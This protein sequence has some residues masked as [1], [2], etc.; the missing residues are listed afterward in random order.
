MYDASDDDE[1]V[2]S[3]DDEWT[4]P[5][6]KLS[7]R[8]QMEADAKNFEDEMNGELQDTMNQLHASN[9]LVPIGASAPEKP[10]EPSKF[11]DDIY[12]DSDIEDEATPTTSKGKRRKKNLVISD[13][14]LLYDPTMDQADQD[15]VDQ[16]RRDYHE[17][18]PR[19]QMTSER[20]SNKPKPLPNSD[21]V[22]NCPACMTLL[23]LDCQRHDK[24]HGQYRAMFVLNCRVDKSQVLNYPMTANKKSIK[25]NKKSKTKTEEDT[26]VP[27]EEVETVE[28]GCSSSEKYNPVQCE[29]CTTEVAVFDN[30]E[31][32]HFFN[33]I[34]GF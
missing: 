26:M 27:N 3:S 11:Y 33:V 12:F 6:L 8:K 23:C 20:N 29:V 14:Q 21:A 9:N 13:D 10:L 25:K 4:M 34:E 19:T 32:F 5:P 1:E 15:W 2:S 22:L 31:V 30:Q 24:Y 17:G 18:P 16:L 7:T 28:E